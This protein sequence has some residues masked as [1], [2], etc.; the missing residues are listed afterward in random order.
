MREQVRLELLGH[1]VPVED[2]VGVLGEG[3]AELSGIL[4]SEVRSEVQRTLQQFQGSYRPCTA[5]VVDRC[6]AA[7]KDG[8][9]SFL[10]MSRH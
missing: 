9:P 1:V 6:I 7:W 4:P 5:W 2:H 3:G 8:R 10:A